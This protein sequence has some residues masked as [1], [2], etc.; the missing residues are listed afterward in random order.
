MAVAANPSQEL[1]RFFVTGAF[2][3]EVSGPQEYSVRDWIIPEAQI[4]GA[5]EDQ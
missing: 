3:F 2:D 1:E 5:K 4:R